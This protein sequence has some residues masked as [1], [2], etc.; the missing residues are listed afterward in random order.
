MTTIHADMEHAKSL[1]EHFEDNGIYAFIAG[2]FIRDNLLGG[3]WRDIDIYVDAN[4][5][6]A[7]CELVHENGVG[8]TKEDAQVFHSGDA[9]YDHQSIS[10]RREWDCH[11][12]VE[13]VWGKK[14]LIDIIG[15]IP[16]IFVDGPNMVVDK[17]NMSLSQVWMDWNG[18]VHYTKLAGDDYKA[19]CCTVL[20]EDW[21]HEKTAKGIRKLKSKYP[22]LPIIMQDGRPYSEAEFLAQ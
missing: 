6:T 13:S 2:G 7:A 3:P 15:I 11:D 22:D 16:D 21:G 4:S 5:F 20:R 9:E 8:Y 14:F 19:R 1:L 17:F 10:R 18:Q 12:G